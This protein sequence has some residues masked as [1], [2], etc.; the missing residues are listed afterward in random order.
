MTAFGHG[1]Y[2]G[3][4]K[5]RSHDAKFIA[6]GI[7]HDDPRC[8]ALANVDSMCAEFNEALYFFFLAAVNW[9]EV[10]VHPVLEYLVLW[11]KDKGER[12]RLWSVA[13]HLVGQ[14]HVGFPDGDP[15]VARTDLLITKCVAP[16]G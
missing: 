14:L 16:K 2:R 8:A 13:Q 6:F 9:C 5:D 10:D 11:D 7:G 4:L 12:R 1:T 15:T 3:L